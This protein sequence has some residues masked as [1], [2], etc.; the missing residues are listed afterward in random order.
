MKSLGSNIKEDIDSLEILDYGLN[1]VEGSFSIN[2][3]STSLHW[4][5]SAAYAFSVC[6]QAKAKSIKLIGFDG[7]TIDDPRHHEMEEVISRYKL[8]DESLDLI[9]LTPTL[10]NIKEELI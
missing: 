10:F 2:P 4:P 3:K 8:L 1:L 6:T 9:S 7:F 5:L